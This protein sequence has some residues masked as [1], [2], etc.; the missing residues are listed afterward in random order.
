MEID[1]KKKNKG[2]VLI[3]KEKNSSKEKEEEINEKQDANI[4]IH[5]NNTTIN[6]VIRTKEGR[7][8]EHHHAKL[9]FLHI[10]KLKVEESLQENS[11]LYNE[12]MLIKIK[13]GVS[14]KDL[15]HML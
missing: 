6:V 9:Y 10:A 15:D 13:V 7:K 2:N 14:Q 1:T 12:I 3:M 8:D 4:D 11:W 5:V